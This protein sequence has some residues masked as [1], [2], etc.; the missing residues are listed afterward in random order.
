MALLCFNDDLDFYRSEIM[1]KYTQDYLKTFSLMEGFDFD[2]GTLFNFNI[3]E[4]TS[5]RKINPIIRKANVDDIDEIIFTYRDVYEGS[6]PY[7]EMEDHEF[8][9]DMLERDDIEWFVFIHPKTKEMCGS[10]T[11]VLDFEEKRG[12]ARGLIV[13]KKFIG[14]F[15]ILKACIGCYVSNYI[16]YDG[17]IFRWYSENRTAHAKVQYVTRHG[18][19]HPVAIYPNKDNFFE[20]PESDVLAICYDMIALTE[21][22]SVKVP[23]IISE[24]VGVFKYSDERYN[25][26]EYEIYHSIPQFDSTTVNELMHRLNIEVSRDNFGYEKYKIFIKGTDSFISFLHTPRVQNIEKTKYQ[27]SDINELY[28]LANQLIKQSR[29]LKVR[30]I[31]VFVSAHKP[32]HQ[33][34]FFELGLS[35]RGYIPSWRYNKNEDSFEDYIVFNQYHGKID[36]NI[37]LMDEEQELLCCLRLNTF[38]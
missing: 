15:D 37:Q 7:K 29:S 22:R 16:K 18:G 34:I 21:M 2:S 19:F 33:K 17:K 35:P 13:K 1:S 3:H 5:L 9:R 38:Y 36:E 8:I 23:C 31:E 25:L 30:Y 20:K 32:E 26:G 14:E 24:V 10:F 6:Y 27:I 4:R 11:F 12:Y 28:V